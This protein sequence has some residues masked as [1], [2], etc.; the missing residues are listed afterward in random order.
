MYIFKYVLHLLH[1]FDIMMIRCI[2]KSHDETKLSLFYTQSTAQTYICGYKEGH[3]SRK[4]WKSWEHF[5]SVVRATSYAETPL[6]VVT[7]NVHWATIAMTNPHKK[8]YHVGTWSW[9]CVVEHS[10]TV[11]HLRSYGH[12]SCSNPY[13]WNSYNTTIRAVS[14][15]TFH[16]E[17]TYRYWGTYKD[18][19]I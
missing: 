16:T 7:D 6:V 1:N 19:K 3:T 15:A 5:P 9:S 2:T 13:Y 4:H 14:S 12:V 17:T 10:T 18:K 11:F 8:S